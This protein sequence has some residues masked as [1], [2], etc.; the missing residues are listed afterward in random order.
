M[1][2][3]RFALAPAEGF[4]PRHTQTRGPA[5]V[6][7][8]TAIAIALIVATTLTLSACGITVSGPERTTCSSDTAEH[9]SALS[10]IDPEGVACIREFHEARF[11]MSHGTIDKTSLGL[12]GDEYAPD[13]SS[14]DGLIDLGILGPEGTLVA[15]TDRIRFFTTDTQPDVDRITYFLVA[16]TPEQFFEM[17]RDGSDAYGIDRASVEDWIGAVSSDGD[18][19]SDYSFQPG[20]SLGMNVNYDVRYDANASKQ[21]VIVD[22]YPL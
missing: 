11:D 17:L 15:S 16:D 14:D 3:A 1:T 6:P 7:R 5:S 8:R 9:T 22:V 21:I 2:D 12:R 20:T 13:V 10:T 18:G 19:V 4:P